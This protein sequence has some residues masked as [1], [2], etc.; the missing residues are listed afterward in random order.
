MTVYHFDYAEFETEVCPDVNECDF[1]AHILS[2][3]VEDMNEADNWFREYL[4]YESDLA[5]EASYNILKYGVDPDSDDADAIV[6]V[7]APLSFEDFLKF[8][9]AE[10]IY[11]EFKE[12]F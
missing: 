1:E 10:K 4:W 8:K 12:R 3:Y 5:I 2:S 11:N 6:D 7:Y 9:K